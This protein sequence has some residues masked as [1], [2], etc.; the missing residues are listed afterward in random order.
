[1]KKDTRRFPLLVAQ[2]EPPQQLDGGDFFY[3]TQSPGVA[4]AQENGVYVVN[5][6]NE[7]REKTDIMARADVL[8]LKNICDP[9][10]LPVIAQRKSKGLLTAYEI[11]DDVGALQ[12]WN[13]VSFFFKNEENLALFRRMA[14]SCDSLQVTCPELER[15]YGYLNH[16][17]KVFP[18][19]ILNIPSE[20]PKKKRNNG[21]NVIIGWGGSHGH[22]EDMAEISVP[23]MDW[24]VTQPNVLL[25]LMCSE[26][27]W[28]LF[29][30]LPQDKKVYIPP[31]SIESYYSFL[32][33]IDIGIGPLKDTPYNRS[34]SDVKYLEYAV[35]EVVPVMKCL[36]P[37]IASV[38]HGKTGFLFHDTDELIGILYRLIDD[39]ELMETISRAA[40]QYVIDDRSEIKHAIDRLDFYEQELGNLA[41]SPSTAEQSVGYFEELS[42]LEGAVTS[43]RHVKL[44]P[45]KF[46]ALLHDGLVAM[47]VNKDAALAYHLF[48]EASVMEPGNYLS[49]LYGS[50]VSPDPV[51]YL[52]QAIQRN[53]R[54]LQAWILLGQEL[55]R[56]SKTREAMECFESAVSV[57]PEYEVPF[58]RVAALLEKLGDRSQASGLLEKAAAMAIDAP[59]RTESSSDRCSV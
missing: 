47:Q 26:P 54:S 43:G 57:Y 55:M 3:R 11:A 22:L 19:Q 10:I 9:D 38:D 40:R 30:R 35:S 23:L 44:E 45:T 29:D 50:S 5:L 39:P 8:V 13:P 7:H 4:M 27:I 46:E 42:S 33:D 24:L 28:R 51:A 18:N 59:C 15:I 48:Q 17:S 25:H 1:M 32:A 2:V 14:A 20:T 34:R 52:F 41:R 16:N 36:V 56:Q 58:L 53:P 37:F 21:D 31:G 6:T 12:S 49:F